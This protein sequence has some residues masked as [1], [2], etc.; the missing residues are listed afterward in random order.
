MT[1]RTI[2]LNPGAFFHARP[3]A[4]IAES[5][6][7]FDSVIMMALGTEI[8]DARNPLSLMR[9]SHPDDSPVELIADG[10]DEEAALDEVL[11]VIKKEL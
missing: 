3:A 6:K 4:R 5:A 11:R 9:L 7:R 10:P 1:T 8:A 2:T